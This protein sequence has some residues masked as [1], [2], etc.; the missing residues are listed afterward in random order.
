M[1]A[2][3]DSVVTVF[4]GTGL[5]AYLIAWLVM[6]EEPLAETKAAVPAQTGAAPAASR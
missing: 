5:L 2:A 4:G 1:A 3:S 6:P